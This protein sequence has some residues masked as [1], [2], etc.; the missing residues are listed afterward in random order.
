MFTMIEV[1][2]MDRSQLLQ[3]LRASGQ[4]NS[5][6]NEESPEWQRAFELYKLAGGGAVDMGCSSC[7]NKVRDWMLNEKD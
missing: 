7:W 1:K 3:Q 5:I 6:G 2:T 4:I